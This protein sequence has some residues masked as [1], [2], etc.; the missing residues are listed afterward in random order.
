M[1]TVLSRAITGPRVELPA[2]ISPVDSGDFQGTLIENSSIR[3]LVYE[4]YKAWV[5]LTL[6][7]VGSLAVLIY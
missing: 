1:K 4:I 3:A 2:L 7:I 5:A 6:V